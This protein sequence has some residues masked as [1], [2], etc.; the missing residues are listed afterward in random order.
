MAE[1]ECMYVLRVQPEY[2]KDIMDGIA[3]AAH[4]VITSVT[5]WNPTYGKS[6]NKSRAH[7]RIG[8][9]KEFRSNSMYDGY[10]YIL[11]DPDD[12]KELIPHINNVRSKT[13]RT[14]ICK[15]MGPITQEE[16]EAVTDTVANIMMHSRAAI[17]GPVETKPVAPMSICIGRRVQIVKGEMSGFIGYV[18]DFLKGR[19]EVKLA[20]KILGRETGIIVPADVIVEV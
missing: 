7:S 1:A 20:V 11:A 13:G 12:I 15:F 18:V 5:F 3:E 10:L 6:S 17:Q 9:G 8:Y 2:M 14:N 4:E 19:T 16:M